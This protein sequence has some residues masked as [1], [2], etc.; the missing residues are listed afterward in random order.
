MTVQ[1]RVAT[2]AD[3]PGILDLFAQPDFND[4]KVLPIEDARRLLAKM[5]TYPN[6]RTFVAE[7]GGSIV[8]T[9][10][11]LVMDNLAHLGTPSAIVE[12]VAVT[13]VQQGSGIGKIMMDHAMQEARAAG[14]YKIVL[15]SN[16]KREKAH[17]FYDG[18]DYERHGISFMTRIQGAP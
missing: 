4:G 6:Y 3:L 9:F 14:C 10:A 5:A 15:S 18:L 16:M 1:I 2:E 17:A 8:G 7:R 11:L 13:P 12:S